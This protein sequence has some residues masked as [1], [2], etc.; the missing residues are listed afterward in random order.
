MRQENLKNPGEYGGGQH[1]RILAAQAIS[2]AELW[3]GA[4]GRAKLAAFFT[5]V[6]TR[7][8]NGGSSRVES[9]PTP[10]VIA[11]GI[12]LRFAAAR[13]VGYALYSASP[14]N[15]A[16]IA[17]FFTDAAS[18]VPSGGAMASY[19]GIVA[20]GT[21]TPNYV[22]TANKFIG[23]TSEHTMSQAVTSFQ[24][25]YA[26]WRVATGEVDGVAAAVS[27]GVEY[28]AGTFTRVTFGGNAA[29]S[30]PAG[31]TTVSD[32]IP[33]AIPAGGKFKVHI[34]AGWPSGFFIATSE[35]AYHP[36]TR[37]SAGAATG[38][39]PDYSLGGG[40]W[41]VPAN[42]TTSY[43]FT[44]IAIIANTNKPTVAVWGSSTG[45]G[46]GETSITDY[47]VTGYLARAFTPTAAVMNLAVSGDS[48]T[49][50]TGSRAKRKDLLK[51]VTHVVTTIGTNDIYGTPAWNST[52]VINAYNTL[53]AEIGV[54]KKVWPA[55]Y[56]P[57]NSGS[58]AAAGTQT[59]NATFEGYRV[60][61]NNA[62]KAGLTGAA[63][64]IDGLSASERA[65]NPEDG[66]W[67]F[68]LGVSTTDGIHMNTPTYI[69]AAALVP[70][71]TVLAS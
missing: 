40:E 35:M 16:A 33:V 60:A 47:G 37:F 15:R 11:Q 64:Y 44:P 5:A 22:S 3:M 2:S 62:I 41:N 21:H 53:I 4:E 57:R 26:N 70:V 31:S 55:L 14:R 56:Q 59:I 13:A 32:A 28:P 19:L 20:S 66:I 10:G 1:L 68:D 49:N 12:S 54:G 48:F 7:I 42:G 25:V 17:A 24:L 30:L 45:R 63:G 43:V 39:I 52:Q 9:L 50:S 18:K 51:Y 69:R 65:V 38:D 23:A 6:A 67:R 8:T 27:V 58:W 36:S 46:F 61:V 29:G 71:T 34:K